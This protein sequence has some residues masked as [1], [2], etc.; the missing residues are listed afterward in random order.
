MRSLTE[1]SRRLS[2]ENGQWTLE[3]SELVRL[4]RDLYRPERK[5]IAGA[6]AILLHLQS[7]GENALLS[8]AQRLMHHSEHDGSYEALDGDWVAVEPSIPSGRPSRSEQLS[9][10]VA[11]L[12]AEVVLLRAAYAGVASRLRKLERLLTDP[13]GGVSSSQ[14]PAIIANAAEQVLDV[15]AAAA[16]SMAFGQTLD[17]GVA[18]AEA[19]A[20]ASASAAETATT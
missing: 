7:K 16:S 8:A 20:G 18:S 14:A 19:A 9:D 6:D 1:T 13:R 5:R 2:Y 10:E 17:A 12:K 4:D 11:E 3:T 15:K